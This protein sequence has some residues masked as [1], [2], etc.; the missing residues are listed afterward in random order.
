MQSFQQFALNEGTGIGIGDLVRLKRPKRGYYYG[1]VAGFKMAKGTALSGGKPAAGSKVQGYIIELQHTPA[2][3][4]AKGPEE[5]FKSEDFDKVT[6]K[7]QEIDD[8]KNQRNP[9]GVTFKGRL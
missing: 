2:S 4:V 1:L 6:N 8:F 3:V 9:A 7:Q 5:T